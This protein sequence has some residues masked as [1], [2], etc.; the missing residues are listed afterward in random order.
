[1]SHARML[2]VALSLTTLASCAASGPKPGEVLDA[3][4]DDAEVA[5]AE[6]S[7]DSARQPTLMGE[8]RSGE[9]IE[10]SFGSGSSYLAWWFDA[11]E[12]QSILLQAAGAQPANLDTVLVLYRATS[13]GRPT[14]A[15][16]ALNDDVE[17]GGVESEIEMRA[18][19][20]RRYVALVRRYDRGSSGSI[21]ISLELSSGS[22]A[23]ASTGVLCTEDC[24]GTGRLP[25][26]APCVRG[27]FDRATCEC[28]RAEAP[29]TCPATGVRCTPEC[30]DG[31]RLPGGAPCVRG[32]F[33]RETCECN[34]IMPGTDC[35]LTGVLC[36]PECDDS[37]RL[38]GGAP[39]RRGNFDPAT[40]ECEPV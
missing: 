23:C 8:I 19:E 37:G 22:M 15:S 10:A 36:T 17:G 14:G 6:S 4:A 12:G 25:S 9:S 28:V 40:C 2:S 24:P 1:M 18:E 16:I 29:G 30:S 31:G 38:P 39:C 32:N 20:T 7:T 27:T 3:T 5:A 33:D 26:G 34:E 11:E 21:E 35:P 13:G